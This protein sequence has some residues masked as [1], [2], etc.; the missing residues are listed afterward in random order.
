[1]IASYSHRQMRFFS[2][3]EKSRLEMTVDFLGAS[4]VGAR[5]VTCVV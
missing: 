3:E 2:L 1:M 4:R 5:V